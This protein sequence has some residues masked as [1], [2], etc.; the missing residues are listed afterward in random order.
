[1]L[2]G[3][4]GTS[5]TLVSCIQIIVKIPEKWEKERFLNAVRGVGRPSP[6]AFPLTLST[7][8][9]M[10]SSK[11][12]GLFFWVIAHIGY[13]LTNQI[14]SFETFE[15]NMVFFYENT[16]S[17]HFWAIFTISLVHK[18]HP[19]DNG[20]QCQR[21]KRNN[22]RVLFPNPAT[23]YV[24]MSV[25][26]L[27]VYALWLFNLNDVKPPVAYCFNGLARRPRELNETMGTAHFSGT[28]LF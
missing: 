23:V 14:I 5:P 2:T 26:I 13:L 9:G 18:R 10:S 24:G 15:K 12:Q 8:Q 17:I 3:P 6:H 27:C 25:G 11:L 19:M 4:F 1:M 7:G 22:R 16:K 21:T 20:I 28:L